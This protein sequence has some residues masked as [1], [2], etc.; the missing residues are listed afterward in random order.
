[1]KGGQRCTEDDDISSTV[2]LLTPGRDYGPCSASNPTTIILP[3]QRRYA[4]REVSIALNCREFNSFETIVL[5]IQSIK[6]TFFLLHNDIERIFSEVGNFSNRRHRHKSACSSLL[7]ITSL[8]L[9]SIH[10]RSPHE[11]PNPRSQRCPTHRLRSSLFKFHLPRRAIPQRCPS[12]QLCQSIRLL[13]R[14]RR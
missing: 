11:P 9:L 10:Q 12:P 2:H 5:S 8:T 14:A 4:G 6:H 1:M 13:R 3:R 7:N